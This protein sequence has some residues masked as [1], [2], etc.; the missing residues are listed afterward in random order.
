MPLTCSIGIMAYNEEA[1][2]GRLLEAMVSQQTKKVAITEIVIVV[3]GCTDNTE[4]IAREW[5][6]RDKRVRVMVQEKRMGK[7]V[8]VNEYLPQAQERIIVL[9]SADVLP[10][11]DAIEHLVSPMADPEVGMTSSRPVPV[12]DPKKFMGFAAHMLWGLHHRIN[13]LSFKAG[14]MIEIGRAH[15]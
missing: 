4:T 5:A 12:N 10:E 1:N 8:A 2:I 6:A 13:L 7:A 9:C 15:V 3:S 11:V 14:E